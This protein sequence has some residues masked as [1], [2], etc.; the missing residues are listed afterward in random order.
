MSK[1]IIDH[2]IE[3]YA[4]DFTTKE[5]PCLARLNRE[6][7]A[8]VLQPVMLSGHL[9]GAFLQM[10]SQMVKPVLALEIGTFT[11]YSAI[12][13][14]Q[15]LTKDGILHTIDIEE[16][17]EE[18]CKTYFK[19]A[20]L[21]EKIVFHLGDALAI[22]PEIPGQFD[23]V[24][25]DADKPNYEAYF[26]LVIDRVKPGGIILADNVLYEGDVLLPL[27]KQNRNTRSI[28]RF[29]EKV[30][31]DPRVEHVLL[32]IRDGLMMIRRK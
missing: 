30:S 20:G 19:E 18:M 2:D 16:E 15:G 28:T 21:E 8:K 13:L 24:F 29:N 26:D 12:C 14:A 3:K 25:I 17:L 7:Y 22:I 1:Q 10:V 6:T 5:S 27:E 4:V 32:P 11:G 23:L 9:Q 31:A